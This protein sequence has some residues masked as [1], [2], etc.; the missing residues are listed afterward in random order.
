MIGT[1]M[2]G[3]QEGT[4]RLRESL[5][6]EA[7]EQL[8]RHPQPDQP[9]PPGREAGPTIPSSEAAPNRTGKCG[10][11]AG[12]SPPRMQQPPLVARR[13][14]KSSTAFAAFWRSTVP[15]TCRSRSRQPEPHPEPGLTPERQSSHGM[16]T[17]EVV[18]TSHDRIGF[19]HRP[20]AP[21]RVTKVV[22][23]APIPLRD[24]RPPQL[25]HRLR[26]C[27]SGPGFGS[28]LRSR[29]RFLLLL[30][31]RHR[32][33]APVPASERAVVSVRLPPDPLRRRPWCGRPQAARSSGGSFGPAPGR[34][35]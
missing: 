3:D 23:D 25:R 20:L 19:G 14:S 15:L 32:F 24:P 26:I 29:I 10:P 31:L 30:P 9:W 16:A 5:P 11:V 33:T 34:S 6:P 13:R 21:A 18:E 2:D 27:G 7:A 17:H 28:P 12:P 35:A 22:P 1:A 8:H 4:G